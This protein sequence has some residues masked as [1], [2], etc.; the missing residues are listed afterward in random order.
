MLH[1]QLFLQVQDFAKMWHVYNFQGNFGYQ[2]SS[3]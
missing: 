1:L 2:L 3:V